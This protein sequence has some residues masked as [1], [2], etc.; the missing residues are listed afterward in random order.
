MKNRNSIDEQTWKYLICTDIEPARFYLLP[1][2]HKPGCPGRPIVASNGTPTEKISHFVD[3][4]LRP[5]VEQIPSF[6]KDA[7]HFLQK[8][9]KIT[10]LPAVSLLVTLDVS[11]LYTNIPHD[12][13]ILACQ[14]ALLL[15]TVQAPPTHDII[16][17]ISCIL[18]K[19]NFV[20]GEKHYLQINGTAMG[21][22]MAP[23]YANLFMAKLEESFLSTGTTLK[24]YVWWRYID[25]IFVI[26][27]HGEESLKQFIKDLNSWHPSI[28]FTAQWS[29]N[30]IPFL[31]TL[32]L[33]QD[34]SLSVDLYTKPTDTH[35][36]LA[37]NSCHP[38][39]CKSSIPFSQALRIRRICSTE[40][41][42]TKHTNQLKQYLVQ[43]GYKRSFLARQYKPCPSGQQGRPASA[44]HKE[45]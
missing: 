30:S 1:K 19:N 17:L 34:G 27:Q 44:T 4:H 3:Y 11:S 8:L 18:T 2:I 38:H 14:S 28:K 22:R 29:S 12:D 15:R 16:T 33:L 9:N 10:S 43:R 5:L 25:D 41:S 35:Q 36:Y 39:H 40:N 45:G 23:S 24:P 32:V 21:T 6:L 37:A 7:T 20:F 26:W 42:F 13:G 31:D